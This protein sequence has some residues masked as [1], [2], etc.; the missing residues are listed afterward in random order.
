M[1]AAVMPVRS[2]AATPEVREALQ[3]AAAVQMGARAS[4]QNLRILPG[5]RTVHVNMELAHLLRA[6]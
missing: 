2:V 1:T 5:R 6:A 3:A 4:P